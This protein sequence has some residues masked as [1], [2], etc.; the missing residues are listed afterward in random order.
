MDK[1]AVTY[2]IQENIGI[3]KGTNQPVNALSF[4]VRKG[5]INALRTLLDNKFK[6]C[7]YEPSPVAPKAAESNPWLLVL[8]IFS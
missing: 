3:I 5:L 1:Q 2:E 4:E 8:L 7:V 6:A